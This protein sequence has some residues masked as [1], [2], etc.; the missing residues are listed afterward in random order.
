MI[1][2]RLAGEQGRTVFALPGRVDQPESQ[3]CLELIRD[4]ATLVRNSNDILDEI[5]PMIGDFNFLDQPTQSIV[6]Q[7]KSLNSRKNERVIMNLLRKVTASQLINY[8][9]YK[10][11]SFGITSSITMIEIQ[12]FV[13]KRADGNMKSTLVPNNY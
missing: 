11:S 8:P 6:K 12:G 4:G 10:N 3:G 1:T 9:S 2:A 5:M 13:S 7:E